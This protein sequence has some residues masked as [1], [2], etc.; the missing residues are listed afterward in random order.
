M[1]TIENAA[2]VIQEAAKRVLKQ[3]KYSNGYLS[4]GDSDIAEANIVI[5]V[6]ALF[7]GSG[8]HVWAES[9]FKDHD[10]NQCKHLDLLVDVASND[11]EYSRLLTIEAK[12]ITA[13]END[14]KIEEILRDYVRIQLWRT[15]DESQ[16]PLFYA[17]FQPVE[18]FY[19]ALVVIVP[20]PCDIHGRVAASPLS[21]W[22]RDLGSRPAGFSDA[23]IA[24]LEEV[25]KTAAVHDFEQAED[26]WD[27]FDEEDPTGTRLAVL[28]ALF[29]F[30]PT[31]VRSN[32][33]AAE[34]EAAHA[35]VAWRLGMPIRR[36]F[37]N[38]D[39][40]LRGGTICD[41]ESLRGTLPDREVCIRGFAVAYAGAL[42]DVRMEE[43]RD[44]DEIFN[45]LP[46]DHD[47]AADVRAK[48]AEWEKVP[49]NDRT[50]K[51]S[52][53]GYQLADS[54]VGEELDRIERLGRHLISVREMAEPAIRDWFDQD[55]RPD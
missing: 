28:Y 39:G 53:K 44:F 13:G 38:D 18:W 40:E 23:N 3:H 6:A 1:K 46:T 22:W 34:H 41:W 45:A 19:G 51:E 24:R 52:S 16:L 32:L 47:A 49:S 33:Q 2:F 48:L 15:L 29:D 26:Y 55:A 17:V 8:C 11:P 21:A 4:V 25:L 50:E 54:L 9:P 30:G 27:G 5:Q 12:R 43:D 36:L 10:G 42:H 35:V 14:K 37:L 31:A 7:I 20:E